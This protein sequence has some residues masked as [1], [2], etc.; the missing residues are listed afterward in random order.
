MRALATAFI[1][2]APFLAIGLIAKYAIPRWMARKGAELSDVHAQAG[3]N[4]KRSV[5]LLGAWRREDQ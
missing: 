1:Y 5:F 4:R 2:F 3:P